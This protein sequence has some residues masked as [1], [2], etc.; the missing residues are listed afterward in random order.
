VAPCGL[1][2]H[3][4][5]LRIMLLGEADDFLRLYAAG[6][7]LEN[8]AHVEVF[9]EAGFGHHQSSLPEASM[10]VAQAFH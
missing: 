10:I 9:Q 4:K 6:F 2:I 1:F 3:V 7:R 8:L 5:G